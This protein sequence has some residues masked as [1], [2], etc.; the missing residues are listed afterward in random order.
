MRGTET[1]GTFASSTQRREIG[2]SQIAI[3]DLSL[4]SSTVKS[5]VG[6]NGQFWPS[7]HVELD[8]TGQCTT[9]IVNATAAIASS[10]SIGS[11]QVA[12]R[13][14]SSCAEAVSKM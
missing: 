4:K 8:Q 7:H 2:T 10:P 13:R 6:D 5:P 1:V 9:Y 12:G 11:L 14:N 3:F